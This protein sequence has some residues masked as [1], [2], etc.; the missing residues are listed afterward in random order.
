MLII[1]TMEPLHTFMTDLKIAGKWL[2]TL[3]IAMVFSC[4][5]VIVTAEKSIDSRNPVSNLPEPAGNHFIEGPHIFYKKGNAIV[6]NI[7]F[8]A[9]GIQVDAKA[10]P[11]GDK[12]PTLTCHI[13]NYKRTSFTVELKSNHISPKTVYEQPEKLFAIS[14]IEGNFEAFEKSLI[15]NGIIDKKLNW[16]FGKGHLVL[17]GDFF[18]RGHNVTAVLWLIY[19]L[20]QEAAKAGGMVHFIIGN[21]EEMN[22][23]GDARYV[24]DKYVKAAKVLK[25]PYR[26]FYSEDTELG[27]WLR[28][29]NVVEKIGETIFVHGGISPEMADYRIRLEEMNKYARSYFGVDKFRLDQRG[30]AANRV[31]SKVGPM[32]Y[33]GYFREQL[34]QEE[35]DMTLNLYGAKQVVVGHTI[36]PKVSNLFEGRV[37]A[38]DV[39]HNIALTEKI[40]NSIFIEN[41]KIYASNIEGVRSSIE[42]FMTEDVVKSA[43]R[44]IRDG[45]VTGIHNFLSSSDREARVN[46]HYFS[47]RVTLLQAAILHNQSEIVQFLI[48]AGADIELLSENKTPLMHA[49]KVNNQ[50]IIDILIKKGADINALN[51]QNKT[52]LFFCAKYGNVEIARVLVEKGAKLDIK[53]GKGRTAVEYAIKNDNKQVAV[54][55]QNYKN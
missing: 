53:D 54:F 48:D 28:S 17:V 55:L 40:S 38:I 29:K 44:A 7:H 16:K 25:I 43:F 22:M 32:W 15:G 18:D 6:K 50:Y 21:H 39:K 45:D 8:T 1:G 12:I 33:R 27:R 11:S 52:P 9:G 14:D 19:K 34:S 51:R 26:S 5:T 49:I 4:S 41:G 35:V 42:H 23:R 36:V 30:G 31:F 47:K 24:K 3:V 2:T 20:E 13:D 46:K 37:I 10:Y